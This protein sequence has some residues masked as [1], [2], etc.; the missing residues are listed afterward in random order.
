MT[1]IVAALRTSVHSSPVL[2]RLA[3]VLSLLWSCALHAAPK[4][5]VVI[6]VNGDRFTGEVKGLEKGILKYSTDFVGT[7]SVE[8]NHVA[9]LQSAQLFEVE[10][11]DGAKLYGRPKRLGDPGS[12]RVGR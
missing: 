12:P 10:L 8:W 2:W 11:F 3:G 4:T 7:I 6:L 1:S 9:Q 5:D